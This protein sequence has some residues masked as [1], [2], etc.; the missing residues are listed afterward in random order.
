MNVWLL[1]AAALSLITCGLHVFVRGPVVARPLL[2]SQDLRTVAKYTNYYCWHIV[3]LVLLLMSG[4]F[5]ISAMTGGHDL[6]WLAFV[7]AIA[8]MLW[9]LAL[10]ARK[11]L[12]PVK[13]PQWALF[14]SIASSAVLG[15]I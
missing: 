11:R 15:L 10:V 8:F 1:T 7:Q 9:S 14:L 6:A 4:S 13:V 12:D 5:V 3:T 2:A